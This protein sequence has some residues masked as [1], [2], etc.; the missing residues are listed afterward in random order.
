MTTINLAELGSINFNANR[1]FNPSIRDEW[2][3]KIAN[4]IPTGSKVIDVAA[5]NR[6]YID[7]FSHCEYFSHEFEGNENIC[8]IFRG[9]RSKPT[10]DFIGDITTLPIEDESFDFVL[11]TEVFEHIPEPIEAMRELVRI[12]KK[13]GQIAITAPFTSGSHQ[14]PY[15]FYAGFSPEFYE[16]LA[17]KFGLKICKMNTQGDFFKL[18]CYFTNIAMYHCINNTNPEVMINV[19]HHMEYFYLTQSE[20]YGDSSSNP[21]PIS[22][23]F[24]IGWCVLFEKL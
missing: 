23:H 6:P 18:M 14:Q 1:H 12:C 20:L 8:D 7:M 3:K 15:H 4:E 13:G 16:Y 2:V 19:R 10:H 24:T 11:C 21:I 17:K 9:E 22:Q 5:G